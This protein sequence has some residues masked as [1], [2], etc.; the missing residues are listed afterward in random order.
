[1]NIQRNIYAGLLIFLVFL[2]IPLYLD[3]IGVEQEQNHE[4]KE[5][6]D[7][8]VENQTVSQSKSVDISYLDDKSEYHK[9][10]IHKFEY[11]PLFLI[12]IEKDI[13]I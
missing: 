2:T 4:T 6:D 8:P 9:A 5:R 3:F 1:M 12:P 13:Y 10:L 7:Y 11:F